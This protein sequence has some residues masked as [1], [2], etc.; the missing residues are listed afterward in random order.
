MDETRTRTPT[1]QAGSDAEL[2]ERL[3]GGDG[4][5]LA[6]LVERY[7][8]ALLRHARALIGD[9]SAHHDVVQDTFLKLLERPPVLPAAIRGDAGAESAHLASW[10]HKVTRN[11]CMDTL[12][13]EKR[14][15]QREESVAAVETAREAHAGGAGLVEARDTRAAVE[16]G[17][18]LLHP[19]QREV[20]VLRLIS[21]RSYKEIA[22][23]TGR[24]IGT[25]GWLISEGLTALADRLGPLL[26]VSASTQ[27]S[28][29]TGEVRG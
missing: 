24:K 9:D 10:L 28:A 6:P 27:P 17:L 4:S 25:V 11:G 13:S 3:G 18:A 14:R 7:Q 20:L 5:A 16:R 19:D 23:I 2:L 22:E 15:R 21:E 12:R 1:L 26:E 29:R 8:G